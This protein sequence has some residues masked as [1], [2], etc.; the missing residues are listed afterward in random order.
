[1]KKYT[2]YAASL[3]LICGWAALPFK[4]VQCAHKGENGGALTVS[5]PAFGSMQA[6][7]PRHT[8]DGENVSPPLRWSGVPKNAKSIVLICDDPDAPVGT[9]VHWVCY[10]IPASVDSLAQA[11]PTADVLPGGGRQGVND[12]HAPG[13]GGPCPPSGTHRYFFN[14]Y[15]L[16]AMLGLPSGKIRRDVERAMKGHVLD[17]GELAGTYTRK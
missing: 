11:V 2:V 4:A 9:W 12:F 7:P 10:D 14:I 13:Y 5:S 1:M 16:D 15:A 8:C 17:S 6:I 3:L